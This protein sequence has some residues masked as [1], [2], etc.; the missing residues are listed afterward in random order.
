M[1]DNPLLR[2]SHLPYGLP[3][4]AAVREEHIVPAFEQGAAEHLAEIAAIVADPDPPTFDNTIAALERSGQTLNRVETVALHTLAASDA[5]D[6]IQQ[7]E[8][9]LAPRSAGHRDAVFLD[10]GLWQRIKQVATDDPEESQLLEHYRTD[11]VKAGADLDDEQQE[12]LRAINA[13]LAELASDFGQNLVRASADSALVTDDPADLHGLGEERIA[14]LEQ[15]GRYVLPL[16]NTSVQPALA[17]LTDRATREKLYRLST[18]R[19]P[20]N[21]AIAARTAELRAE[22]AGLLGYTDHAAYKVADQTAKTVEAVEERLGRLVE[23][24]RRNVEREAAALAEQAGHEIEPWDWAYYAE[25]VRKERY[26]FDEEALRPYLE[27]DRVI[28]QGVLHAAHLLYGITFTERTD[29]HGYHPD[30]RVWEVFDTDGTGLGLY[31]L[32]PYARPTKEGGAW[33]HNLVAQSF[34]LDDR[35]VVV[36]NLN[37]TK[38]ASGPT[39]LTWDEVETAFHE[40]GHALHGL[41]SAV[42]FPLVEGTSVPRDFVEYPSQ[43]NE[44]WATDPE[45]LAGYARHHESGEPVPAELVSALERANR[46]NQGFSTFEYLAAALLDWSWHRLAPGEKIEDPATFEA[47]ALERAGVAHPLVSPRYRS[48]YFLHIFA[49]DYSA[50]YYSYVWSEV[51]DADSVEWLR[52]HG[53]LR[54]ENGD[55]FREKVLAVGGSVDP[56]GAVRDFLGR[57]PRLEPLLARRGLEA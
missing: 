30:V 57:E 23:P 31:L 36:N 24:A 52:E 44:V 29:L 53:G 7:I 13:E 10:R 33:M 35:P 40:F 8:R 21:L 27:L 15:D 46:F 47:R 3:D 6:G 51:L 11:F 49:G 1:T 12:R 9:E 41:L 25:Q 42:R 34:L 55:R 19:A 20:E 22:H 2:P 28:E 14:A 56:M 17:Q 38:P 48:T 32:D 54:R 45:V 50:G 43:V 37:V 16:L 39:L 5:T 18:E 26:D 4:F